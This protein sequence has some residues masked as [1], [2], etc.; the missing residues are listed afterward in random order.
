ML[1]CNR[2]FDFA[3]AE[4]LEQQLKNNEGEKVGGQETTFEEISADDMECD[5]G[6]ESRRH[7]SRRKTCL[8]NSFLGCKWPMLTTTFGIEPGVG[9]ILNNDESMQYLYNPDLKTWGQFS[10]F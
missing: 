8:H 4:K 5:T 9:N 1:E 6:R 10:N 7:I 2:E 3:F